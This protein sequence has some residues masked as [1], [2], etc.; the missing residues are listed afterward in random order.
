[1]NNGAARKNYFNQQNEHARIGIS[2]VIYITS[3]S[4]TKAMAV[5]NIGS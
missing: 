1:M 2:M 4:V 3:E 5:Y